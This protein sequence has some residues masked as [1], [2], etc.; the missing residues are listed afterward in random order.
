[1]TIEQ[2]MHFQAGLLTVVASGLFSLEDAKQA[3]LEM[4]G[5]VA[6]HKAEKLL[7]DGRSVKGQPDDLERFFYGDFAA[8]ETLRIVGEH[9]LTPRF[10][11]VLHQPLRDPRRFGETVAVNRGMNIQIFENPEDALHWLSK[12]C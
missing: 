10:A 3:F 5:A 4:L 2:H 6:H 12:G 8:Q 7:L 9:K 11:Y 1:M